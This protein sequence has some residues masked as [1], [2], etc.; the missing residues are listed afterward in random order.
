[1]NKCDDCKFC[2]QDYIFDEDEGGRV[3][4]FYLR[5]RTG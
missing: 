1:M 5:K 3:S 2:N 4:A